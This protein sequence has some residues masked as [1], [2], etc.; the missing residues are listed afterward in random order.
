LDIP[1]IDSA[2]RENGL[3]AFDRAAE[4]GKGVGKLRPV[5]TAAGAG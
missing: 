2:V 3:A 4:K 5:R 1:Q